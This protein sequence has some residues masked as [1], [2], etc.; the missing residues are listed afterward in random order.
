[1]LFRRWRL[2]SRY[3]RIQKGK[4]EDQI[5]II[6]ARTS[7]SPFFSFFFFP[8][9]FD[10]RAFLGSRTCITTT[11]IFP[12]C[13]F[14]G[15]LVPSSK[16]LPLTPKPPTPSSSSDSSFLLLKGSKARQRVSSSAPSRSH[17]FIPFISR[18]L[19]PFHV[20]HLREE[21]LEQDRRNGEEFINIIAVISRTFNSGLNR[22]FFS[23]VLSITSSSPLSLI[24]KNHHY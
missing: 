21:G 18:F 13:F 11:E 5:Q 20:H 9:S 24:E 1:M 8:F 19:L 23:L 3:G 6:F 22:I 4:N 2:S 17:L 16:I 15:D 14:M 10:D 7:N 12:F